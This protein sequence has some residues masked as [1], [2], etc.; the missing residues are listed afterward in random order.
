MK[1]GR[2]LARTFLDYYKLQNYIIFKP[3]TITVKNA[4]TASNVETPAANSPSK[5]KKNNTPTEKQVQPERMSSK[6]NDIQT[7]DVAT[8]RETK[9]SNLEQQYYSSDEG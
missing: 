7:E 2:N 3:S 1:L 4:E 5:Q 8:A 9:S 6:L